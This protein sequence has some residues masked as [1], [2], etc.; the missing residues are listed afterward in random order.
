M[1]NTSF[2]KKILL[3]IP[4]VLLYSCDKDFNAV[5][6][7]LIGDDHF[8]LESEKYDVLAYNQE[9]TPVQSNG[10]P[11]NAL[12]IYDDGV[13]S[14]RTASYATQVSLAS[15]APSIGGE[16]VIE[17][18]T[19]NIPYFSHITSTD[20]NGN[21]TY[22]LD[23]IY[24][25]ENG[26]FKL[27][28]YVSGVQ[29]RSSYFDNGAQ[30]TQLYY[31]DQNTDF[32][33]YKVPANN[34]PDVRLNNSSNKF[35]NDEFFFNSLEYTDETTDA[36]G[37]KTKTK[38]APE[39]RLNLDKSFFQT[40][41][42]N[43]D[44]SKL[45]A[46]DVFQ[47]Y[48]R[49]LYFKA[50]KLGAG[51]GNMAL[52]DFSKGK[53]TIKYKAKTDIT[54][55]LETVKEDRT[56]VINLTGANANLTQ[57]VKKTA[58]QTALTSANVTQ[59]DESLYLKGGQGSLAVIELNDFGSKIK[60]I[61][62]KGWLVNEANLVFHIDSDKIAGIPNKNARIREVKRVYLYDLTNNLPIIDYAADGSTSITTDRKMSK[63]IY[64]GIINVD[65]TTKKGTTYKIRLTNHI[66]NVI[67]NADAVNVKLGLVVT[68]DINVSATNKL[69][70]KG[71][72][73]TDA[74][75]AS[76]MSP[77]G[78]VLFGGKSTVPDNKR[79]KLEV[80]YTKPN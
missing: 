59:G 47:E 77:L 45:S 15:Y 19:L 31:T 35:E 32:D 63:I 67:K 11:V 33:T 27:S 48:F 65:A 30:F 69:K 24:G 61:K 4:V 75:R 34:T 21:N 38:V 53:I 52:M 44:A 3:L 18:V 70:L 80:Y 41:I 10:L 71:S 74:P 56:L 60:D 17:S 51:S 66:R 58:Y 9:V 13:F 6:D 25:P 5:G 49:G 28:V 76:V 8:G 2:F 68:E 14:E 54:T 79:L 22:V 26:K 62:G 16:P 36:G 20:E 23:S 39:M 46:S 72:I 57:D 40:K 55:D 12:G 1:Y 7:E 78:T 50:E 42:L 64:S 37:T 73:I 29:M 43:A